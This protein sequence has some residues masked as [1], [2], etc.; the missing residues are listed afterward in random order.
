M[1][2]H[3]ILNYLKNTFKQI[4]KTLRQDEKNLV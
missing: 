1:K 4:I 2:S 3:Q